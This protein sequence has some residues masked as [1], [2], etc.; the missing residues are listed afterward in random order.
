[1]FI[2]GEKNI[3][4]RVDL[5]A[6]EWS[7]IPSVEISDAG[8]LMDIDEFGES[9]MYLIGGRGK[10]AGAVIKRLDIKGGKE[11]QTNE[12]LKIAE[13]RPERPAVRNPN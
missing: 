10:D 3:N 5:K 8:C 6:D 12:F 11:W 4:G 7:D 1:M 13:P 2:V 9:H